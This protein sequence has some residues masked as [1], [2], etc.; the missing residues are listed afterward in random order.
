ML[1]VGSKLKGWVGGNW[2]WGRNFS[3]T[4]L[5]RSFYTSCYKGVKKFHLEIEGVREA[6]VIKS[7]HFLDPT[8]LAEVF[9]FLQ[10]TWVL[11]HDQ[12]YPKY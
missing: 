2:M 5:H 10:K 11:K 9:L 3:L 1:Y 7:S 6:A 4:T 8:L 12:A